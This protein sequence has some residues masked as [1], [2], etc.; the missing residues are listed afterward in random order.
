MQP[1]VNTRTKG[2]EISCLLTNPNGKFLFFRFRL[3]FLISS[4]KIFPRILWKFYY[5]RFKMW[6]KKSDCCEIC[7]LFTSISS[8][9]LVIYSDSHISVYINVYTL[10]LLSSHLGR[11]LFFA[12]KMKWNEKEFVLCFCFQSSLNLFL[13][14]TSLH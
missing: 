9:L 5:T 14:L 13:S 8:L 7:F 2:D 4:E 3:F 10:R 12:T 1:R 6:K 11:F